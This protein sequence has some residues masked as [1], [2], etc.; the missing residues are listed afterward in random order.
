MKA[1]IVVLCLI[2]C[3]A[4]SNMPST[5]S[6]TLRVVTHKDFKTFVHATGY[7]T[8]AE[9]FGWSIVQQDVFDFITVDGATWRKP[10]GAH[11]PTSNQVPVT[12]VSYNDA[13][14]YCQ[15]SGTQLP[16]YDQY[17]EAVVQDQRK[18]VTNYNAPISSAHE[19]NVLGNVWEITDTHK[20]GKICL[21]GGSLFCAPTTCNGTSKTRQ[22]YV[23][24][25]TGNIH[26]GF[27]VLE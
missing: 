26:I 16:T 5:S 23:D 11:P 21:A 19:V 22:L 18:V 7:T 2:I 12:Q 14:A 25:Q 20:R 8:D 24:Q 13:V 10:D 15:W 3:T 27:A 4:C 9:Q 1:F 17:W 6:A